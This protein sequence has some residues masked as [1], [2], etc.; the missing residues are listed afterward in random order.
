MWWNLYEEN[1]A[2]HKEGGTHQDYSEEL[3]LYSQKIFSHATLFGMRRI[4][5]KQC[6]PE[7]LQFLLLEFPISPHIWHCHTTY[8]ARGEENIC[9]IIC[10]LKLLKRKGDAFKKHFRSS[11]SLCPLPSLPMERCKQNAQLY[12]HSP[13]THYGFVDGTPPVVVAISDVTRGQRCPFIFRDSEFS[14]EQTFP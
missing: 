10:K 9:K 4:I 6:Q 12:A 5:F 3:E 7:C 2:T 13:D 11:Q 8:K 1:I 14:A